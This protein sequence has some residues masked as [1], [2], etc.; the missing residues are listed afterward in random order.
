MDCDKLAIVHFSEFSI[1]VNYNFPN[2]KGSHFPDWQTITQ[3]I[4]QHLPAYLSEWLLDR[5]SLTSRL[6]DVCSTD[7]NVQVQNQYYG[8]PRFNE[9]QSLAIKKK[10]YCLIREVVLFCDKTPL[11]FARTVV[12]M[13]TLTGRERRLAHMGSQSLGAALFADP[14]MRRERMEIATIEPGQFLYDEAVKTLV[15]KPD[16]IWGRRS[17]FY[18]NNKKLLISEIF[19]PTFRQFKKYD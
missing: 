7:F 10:A 14:S 17:I 4:R 11:V 8:L 18:L 15:K 1:S 5:S 19:L 16:K 3:S 9:R 12:P 13:A 2:I 6:V